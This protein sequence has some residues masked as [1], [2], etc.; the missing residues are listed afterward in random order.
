MSKNKKTIR[1]NSEL[2]QLIEQYRNRLITMG[3]PNPTFQQAQILLIRDIKPAIIINK[4]RKRKDE[5][6][7]L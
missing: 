1:I 6:P 7:R 2:E 4:K 3:L 5:I